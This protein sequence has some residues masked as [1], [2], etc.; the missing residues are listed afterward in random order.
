MELKLKRIAKKDD[1]TIGHL[2]IMEK[3]KPAYFC[4]TMEPTWRM[5]KAH[6]NYKV[7]G[8]TAIPEGRYPVLITK[9]PK[10]KRWLPLLFGV[11]HFEGI[12]IHAGNFP[13]DT[14]GCI[15]VGQNTKPGILTNSLCTL[16]LLISK[17]TEARCKDEPLWITVE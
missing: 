4:D 10:F 17:M 5:V 11:P 9:S 15:L 7:N 13:K 14:R 12:R 16:N 6:G 3:G 8:R 1:Y 2:Y